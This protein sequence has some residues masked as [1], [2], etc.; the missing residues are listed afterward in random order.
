M[1]KSGCGLSLVKGDGRCFFR[2]IARAGMINMGFCDNA[3]QNA[4]LEECLADR[5][6][7]EAVELI[8]RESG[9]WDIARDLPFLLDDKGG[10]YCSSYGSLD[11]RMA[12]M[13]DVD[14][15]PGFLEI[16][17]VA[18]L[19]KRQV[20]IYE[21]RGSSYYL[22]ARIPQKAY[23]DRVPIRLAYLF[24]TGKTDGHYSLITVEEETILDLMSIG[25]SGS[26]FENCP[27]NVSAEDMRLTLCQILL[28][29]TGLLS[30][31]RPQEA[32]TG[33]LTGNALGWLY[34]N[35]TNNCHYCR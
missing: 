15:Y 28:T 32:T 27:S 35:Y 33:S 17:A 31:Y 5:I 22:H 14:Q 29:V 7:I 13:S 2:C 8:R 23:V 18:H 30:D 24:D 16:A 34:H 20:L 3:L 1:K 10:E 25:S 19:M 6:R 4:K 9:I 21:D 12:A 26:L 11:N